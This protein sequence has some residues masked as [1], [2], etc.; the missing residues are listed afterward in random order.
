MTFIDRIREQ[1]R[2]TREAHATEPVRVRLDDL[3]RQL[4]ELSQVLAQDVEANAAGERGMPDTQLRYPL[5]DYDG[6]VLVADREDDDYITTRDIKATPGFA[7][8][9]A[10][11]RDL[12][13]QIDLRS[14]ADTTFEDRDRTLFEIV[15]SGWA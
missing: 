8:L 12:G 14:E 11:A 4:E 15:V 6:E 10:R 3:G 5:R 1:Y 9:Q 13:L 2:K 7:L